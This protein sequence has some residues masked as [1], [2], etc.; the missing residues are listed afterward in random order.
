MEPAWGR[1]G[2]VNGGPVIVLHVAVLQEA[3]ISCSGTLSIHST[4]RQALQNM[5]G[6]DNTKNLDLPLKPKEANGEILGYNLRSQRKGEL[7]APECITH[8]LQ[9]QLLLPA[10]E[11]FTFYL[12][13]KNT[14]GISPPTKLVI[15]AFRNLEVYEND[16][17][18]LWDSKHPS[19]RE[20]EE[21]SPSHQE[22]MG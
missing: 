10:G 5:P 1:A 4:T 9:C 18:L 19:E 20:V 13:A 7:I 16:D 15:P 22:E 6:M 17:Q 2:I 14:V 11:E 12:T 21:F 8:H 3:G